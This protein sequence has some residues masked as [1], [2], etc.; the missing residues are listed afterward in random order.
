MLLVLPHTQT[1]LTENLRSKE[2]G[3]ETTGETS[4]PLIFLI[5][6]VPCVSSQVTRVTLAFRARLFAEND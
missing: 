2:G 3:M 1:S 5:P 4:S 6:T